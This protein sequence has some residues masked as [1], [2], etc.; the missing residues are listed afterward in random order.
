MEII[1]RSCNIKQTV[2]HEANWELRFV[3][4]KGHDARQMLSTIL[5]VTLHFFA[6]LVSSPANV[7]SN[8]P[9]V[10]R[11]YTLPRAGEWVL[12]IQQ[13][14]QELDSTVLRGLA[15]SIYF[16]ESS[17]WGDGR[18]LE[19]W[20]KQSLSFPQQHGQH[21]QRWT[22]QMLPITSV[23]WPSDVGIRFDLVKEQWECWCKL[24]LYS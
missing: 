20:I 24:W 13:H 11:N 16:K 6:L 19:Y 23:E 21:I 10:T 2:F 9:R 15:G 14:F 3:K 5:S 7:L 4:Y 1:S 22:A 8:A 18:F 12:P 17:F